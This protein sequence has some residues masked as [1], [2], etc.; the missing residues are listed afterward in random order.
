MPSTFSEKFV[1]M[2]RNAA[3]HIQKTAPGPP[4]AMA[5]A[6]PAI[7]PVPMVAANAVQSAWNWDTE[8]LS[9]L[10]W[11]SAWNSP[12]NVFDHQWRRWVIWKKLVAT[13]MR[14]P[15]PSSNARPILTQMNVFRASLKAASFD[16]NASMCKFL[17][18]FETTKP[19]GMLTAL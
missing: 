11:E 9:D 3:T 18:C 12:M 8:R 14:T 6:T 5:A 10:S 16:K 15:V 19:S 1:I 13:L 7:F 4:M 17:S 2:P